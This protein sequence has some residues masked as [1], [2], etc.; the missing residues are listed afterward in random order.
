M[1]ARQEA[2][3][4]HYAACA[5]AAAAAIA[6]GYSAKTARTIGPRL[7]RNVAIGGKV[8][9]IRSTQLAGVIM[10]AQEVLME[11]AKLARAPVEA[12]D[13]LAYGRLGAKC[14]ALGMLVRIHGLEAT[15]PIPDG[16]NLPP[17]VDARLNAIAD[18]IEARDG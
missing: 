6:A 8:N 13:P 7:L 10:G 15:A 5:S 9:E 14:K 2:F 4:V 3:C 11:L 17:A 12:S 16:Q 18:M 1:N